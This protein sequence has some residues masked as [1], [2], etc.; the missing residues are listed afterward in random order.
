[1]TH[2]PLIL[3]ANIGSTSFK[4]RL[5]EMPTER[6]LARGGVDRIGSTQSAWTIRIGS[7][8]AE[9]GTGHF[10]DYASAVALVEE[11]LTGR[12]LESFAELTAFGFKPVMARGISGT[13]VFNE[14]VLE[15][16]A[17][18]SPVF[19]AHNPPYINAVRQFQAAY[20]QI[21][22]LGLFETAFYDEVPEANRHFAIPQ[23]WESEY[24]VLRTGFHGASH[25]FVCQRLAEIKGTNQLRLITC[26]LGGSSSMA[27]VRNGVAQ[28]S[29]W[30]MTA[31]SG[32]P[33]NNRVGDFD[34]F[35]LLYVLQTF[36]LSPEQAAAELSK[37]GGLKGLSGLDSGDIRDVLA[38]A[39]NGQPRAQLALDV[40]IGSIR[41]YLGQFLVELNGA[42]AIIFTAGIGE[43]NPLVRSRVC[44]DLDFCGLRLDEEKNLATKATEAL[45]SHPDSKIEVW[46]LPTNEEIVIARSI[47]QKLQA[48]YS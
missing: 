32:L 25:R 14:R 35:A 7:E 15:A 29:S 22:C 17:A 31:Q 37:E 26:H 42:E 9:E 28:D 11:K 1:M 8:P 36:G 45:I 12:V 41:K 46:V 6:L 43:N 2:H 20:P 24:G 34:S 21:P 48:Q 39:E 40:F 13:Q 38:A 27:C 33:H 30:G 5:Y 18:F 10:P 23:R 19:P 47:F 44:A 16:M 3:V 4:F